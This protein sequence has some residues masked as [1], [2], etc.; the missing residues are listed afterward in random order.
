MNI[1]QLIMFIVI[2]NINTFSLR[3][4]YQ[5]IKWLRL[6]INIKTYSI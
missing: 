1:I 4:G 5:R 6:S 2:T 3:K